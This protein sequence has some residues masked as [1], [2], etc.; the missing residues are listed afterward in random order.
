MNKPIFDIARVAGASMR[1]IRPVGALQALCGTEPKP[2]TNVK[3]TSLWMRIVQTDAPLDK[4][5]CDRCRDKYIKGET[6]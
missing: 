6:P 1:H 2:V 3:A 4:A 5:T